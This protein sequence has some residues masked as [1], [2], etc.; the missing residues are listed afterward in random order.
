MEEIGADMGA[1][2]GSRLNQRHPIVAAVMGSVFFLI[3]GGAAAVFVDIMIR[4]R[5]AG[6]LPW[7]GAGAVVGFTGALVWLYAF[8]RGFDVPLSVG[9]GLM[10]LTL[11]VGAAAFGALLLRPP[12]QVFCAAAVAA[13]LLPHAVFAI[14]QGVQNVRDPAGRKARIDRALRMAQRK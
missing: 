1:R 12:L 11:A 3:A 5:G 10:I 2:I 6:Q 7:V 14:V 9:R 4:S 8:A 13:R